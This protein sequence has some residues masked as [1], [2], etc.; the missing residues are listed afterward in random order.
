MKKIFP[1]E[2][3]KI[4]WQI[5]ILSLT[6]KEGIYENLK[7][8][9]GAGGISIYELKEYLRERYRDKEDEINPQEIDAI[10]KKFGEKD[11]R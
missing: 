7:S 5:D 1:E 3:R 2:L 10:L 9:Y 4:L 11:L 8:R 6:E